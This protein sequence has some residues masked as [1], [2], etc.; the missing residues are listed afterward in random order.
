MACKTACKA[1]DSLTHEQMTNIVKKLMTIENRFCCPHG[2]PT[3][4]N[5]TLK[6]IEKQFKRDYKSSKPAIDF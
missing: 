2:R 4:W 6:E 3:M 5:L 1:G